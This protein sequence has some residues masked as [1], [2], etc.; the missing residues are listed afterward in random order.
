MIIIIIN[1]INES[2]IHCSTP[3]APRIE[4]PEDSKLV[5]KCNLSN[6]CNTLYPGASG[7]APYQENESK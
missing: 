3:L 5:A 2:G 1:M 6:A 7:Y 4:R